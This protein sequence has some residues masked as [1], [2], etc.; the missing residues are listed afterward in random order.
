MRQI[1]YSLILHD[2]EVPNVTITEP[3]EL[4]TG[5]SI[6]FSIYPSPVKEKLNIQWSETLETSVEW[7]L[8]STSGVIVKKGI[9][10]SG[11]IKEEINTQMLAEGIYLLVTKDPITSNV[12]KRKVL[13]IK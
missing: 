9:T 1:H 12:E 11:E 10:Q 7:E 3:E 8:V 5:K 13:I 4:F 6:D 2:I